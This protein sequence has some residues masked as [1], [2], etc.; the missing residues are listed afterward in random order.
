MHS[1]INLVVGSF[2]Y[3]ALLD[4][5]VLGAHLVGNAVIDKVKCLTI[6]KRRTHDD[7]SNQGIQ[8]TL[9]VSVPTSVPS[10]KAM[11]VCIC[12]LGIWRVIITVKSMS[13]V[14]SYFK[15]KASTLDFPQ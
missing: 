2:C 9:S 7:P 10:E 12:H 13:P 5:G 1:Q 4:T 14:N 3:G 6:L 8:A 15:G 11:P